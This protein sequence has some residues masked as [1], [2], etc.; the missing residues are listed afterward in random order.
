MKPQQNLM[1]VLKNFKTPG[2]RMG[3]AEI[4]LD[5]LIKSKNESA[6]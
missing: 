3:E 6:Q 2:D 4:L 5:I 1:L